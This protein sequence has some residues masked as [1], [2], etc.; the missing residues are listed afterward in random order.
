MRSAAYA[1]SFD[2]I[3]HGHLAILEAGASLFEKVYLVIAANADKPNGRFTVAERMEMAREAVKHLPNV[4]VINVHSQFIVTWAA[5]NGVGWVIRGV[6]GSADI[7]P[8]RVLAI[9]NAQIQPKVQTLYIPSPAGVETVSSSMVVGLVGHRG[10]LKVIGQFVCPAVRQGLV[11]KFL[12]DY[13][14]RVCKKA[15]P[16]VSDAAIGPIFEHLVT[17]YTEPHRVYHTLD[18]IVDVL[19]H[20][21]RVAPGG[22]YYAP[23]RFAAFFH[24]FVNGTGPKDEEESCGVAENSMVALGLRNLANTVGDI[25]EA[26]VKAGDNPMINDSPCHALFVDADNAV[27]GREPRDYGTYAEQ[28]RAEYKRYDDA[29]Y[30]AGRIQFLEGMLKKPALFLTDAFRDLDPKARVNM[31]NELAYWRARELHRLAL[32]PK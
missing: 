26:T 16:M 29:A 21:D 18:H 14:T 23:L 31:Q 27:L 22:V 12:R 7:E 9:V 8:E 24:D 4:E 2:P 10:W 17:A 5:D 6:R 11:V 25:I 19:E 28:I 15:N 32:Q 13:F 1:G 20:L 3:T 30:H